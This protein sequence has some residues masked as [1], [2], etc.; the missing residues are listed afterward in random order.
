MI[1]NYIQF[2]FHGQFTVHAI[3]VPSL[4]VYTYAR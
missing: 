3:K 1:G 2:K 4:F